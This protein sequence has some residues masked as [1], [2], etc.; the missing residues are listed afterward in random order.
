MASETEGGEPQET[1]ELQEERSLSYQT[2]CTCGTALTEKRVEDV[3]LLG[4]QRLMNAIND[5]GA[6]LRG[7][8]EG[9]DDDE[10]GKMT[11]L[12][13]KR[14]ILKRKKERTKRKKKG[15]LKRNL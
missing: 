6:F 10:E 2:R 12:R 8:G 1:E 9:G 13:K 14:L 4:M 11:M 7:E 5:I 15:I 3:L